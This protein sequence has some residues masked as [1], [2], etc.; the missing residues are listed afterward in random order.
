VA[1]AIAIALHEVL[2]GLMPATQPRVPPE[3]VVAQRVSI[4]HRP[5]PRPSPSTSPSPRPIAPQRVPIARIAAAKGRTGAAAPHRAVAATPNQA[6]AQIR[7]VWDIPA[8]ANGAHAAPETGLGAAGTA[9]AGSANAG[10]GSGSA[11]DGA[12]TGAGAGNEPCG[13]VTFSDPHGSHFDPHTGGFYVDIRLSVRFADNH[14]ESIILDYPFYYASEA[15][16]PWSSRNLTNPDLLPRLQL[17]P[18]EK[19]SREPAL[20]QYVIAHSTPEGM[21]VL[22]DCPNAAPP[23]PGASG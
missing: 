2:A 20:L 12:G 21:T 9:T 19:M 6:V 18:S 4:A 16:N 11:G 7:P 10:T 13:F 5:T 15:A 3:R 8:S 22:D 23:A 1:F 14:T 17:P